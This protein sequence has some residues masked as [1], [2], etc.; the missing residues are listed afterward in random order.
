MRTPMSDISAKLRTSLSDIP[1]YPMR[2]VNFILMRGIRYLSYVLYYPWWLWRNKS[3]RNAVVWLLIFSALVVEF[4]TLS[5]LLALL[6]I[7]ANF[8]MSAMMMVGQFLLGCQDVRGTLVRS[9]DRQGSGAWYH[10]DDVPGEQSENESA[11][12]GAAGGRYVDRPSW[13]G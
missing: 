4:F 13:N 12:R 11:W 10:C 8:A 5:A 9:G 1:S 3:L 7:A 6:G 2:L